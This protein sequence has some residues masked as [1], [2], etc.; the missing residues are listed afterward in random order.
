VEA[1]LR[2]LQYMLGQPLPARV[3]KSQ[4]DECASRTEYIASPLARTSMIDPCRALKGDTVW[5]EKAQSFN[6]GFAIWSE[7]EFIGTSMN[8]TVERFDQTEPQSEFDP[9]EHLTNRPY[10][11]N[12][13]L[14]EQTDLVYLL[15]EIVGSSPALKAVA[16]SV[17]IVAPAGL[18][19]LIQGETGTGKE[20]IARAIHNLSPRKDK[21]FVK[22]NGAA[23]PSGLLESD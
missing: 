7:A 5:V 6:P 1:I 21:A 9:S 10:D 15:D 14:R 17:R 8:V 16:D 2:A 23:T 12:L 13:K 20:M 18:I 19:V 11:E 4:A 3:G 22:V